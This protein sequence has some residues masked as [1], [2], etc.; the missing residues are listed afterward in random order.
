MMARERNCEGDS[1][2]VRWK[3]RSIG[4]AEKEPL[5]IERAHLS[6][7]RASGEGS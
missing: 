7:Q 3:R 1:R 2:K 4:I 5:E 6:S